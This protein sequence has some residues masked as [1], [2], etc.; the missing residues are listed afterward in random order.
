MC[1]ET[2]RIRYRDFFFLTAI[3]NAFTI[4]LINLIMNNVV[5]KMK[6][7]LFSMNLAQLS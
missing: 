1:F 5:C 2:P 3:K 7:M 6:Q 4:K